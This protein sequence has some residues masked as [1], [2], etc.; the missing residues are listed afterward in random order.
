MDDAA[1][2]LL[3]AAATIPACYGTLGPGLPATALV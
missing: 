2:A 3:F 1:P